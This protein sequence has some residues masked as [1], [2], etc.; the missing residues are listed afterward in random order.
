MRGG[1]GCEIECECV[2]QEHGLS[3]DYSE[4]PLPVD[5][6]P[7]WPNHVYCVSCFLLFYCFCCVWCVVGIL[8]TGI[9]AWVE[10]PE[11]AE[12]SD[13]HSEAIGALFE[14]LVGQNR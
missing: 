13:N 11:S 1:S 2:T 4:T 5:V 3:P 7:I 6:G 14:A 9:R 12:Q 10:A 8:T